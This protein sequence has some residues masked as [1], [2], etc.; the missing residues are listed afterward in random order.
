V[1]KRKLRGSV[2]RERGEVSDS[3]PC[4]INGRLEEGERTRSSEKKRSFNLWRG[5]GRY[6]RR[7][8]KASTRKSPG[9]MNEK[10]FSHRR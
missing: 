8:E 10:P 2:G 4:K 3:N 7:G 1:K 6:F 5:C 9:W